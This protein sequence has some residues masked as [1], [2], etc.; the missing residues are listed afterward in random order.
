M[1]TKKISA[2]QLAANRRNAQKSTGPRTAAGRETCSLNAVKHGLCGDFG[3]LRGEDA[4]VYATRCREL[5]LELAPATAMEF[6]LAQTIANDLWRLDRASALEINMFAVGIAEAQIEDDPDPDHDPD[7][8]QA[9][10]GARTFLHH[11]GKFAL[12]SLYEQRLNRSVHKNTAQLRQMQAER[13]QAIVPK[14][15]PISDLQAKNARNG[16]ERANNF[17]DCAPG[18]QAA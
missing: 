17:F 4:V 14:P 18:R 3:L 1:R 2:R 5:I 6:N 9:L 10:A 11:T 12:L 7:M 8:Q 16:F 15:T 13:R